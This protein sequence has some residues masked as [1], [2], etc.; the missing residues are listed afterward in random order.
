MFPAL[1][2]T[3]TADQRAGQ[4]PTRLAPE[5]VAAQQARVE[6][7]EA[8]K[9]AAS[10]QAIEAAATATVERQLEPNYA[11]AG[12]PRLPGSQPLPSLLDT[13]KL[14]YGVIEA[15]RDV[16]PQASRFKGARD[17]YAAFTQSEKHTVI[18]RLAK[19]AGHVRPCVCGGQ[20]EGVGAEE[21]W[22]GLARDGGSDPM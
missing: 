3:E 22:A 7:A 1:K 2:A 17:A 5:L 4:Q 15:V 13:L 8:A 16:E 19:L 10:E 20:G 9:T 14:S 11:P 21:L 18:Y 6:A 12:R